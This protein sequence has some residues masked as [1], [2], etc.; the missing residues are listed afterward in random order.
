MARDAFKALREFAPAPGK[1]G[2]YYSLAALEQAGLGKISRL[3]RSI[4]VVL[5]ALVRQCDGKL[6]TE[7]HVRNLAAW[8][9]DGKRT[10]EIPFIVVRIVLQD[11]IGFGTLN[12]L[13][14]MRAAAGRLGVAPGS[15]EPLVPVDVVVDHSVEIDVHNAPDAVQRNQQ[16]EFKRTRSAT[17]S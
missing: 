15:I 12:D 17:S 13:S 2:R 9:P 10:T 3:P 6:V 14:A 8:Q 7:E 1:K 5:E 11:L 4:R 16:I